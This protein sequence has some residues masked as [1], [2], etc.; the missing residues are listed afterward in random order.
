[1]VNNRLPATGVFDE[2]TADLLLKLQIDDGYKDNGTIPEGFLYKVHVDFRL[3]LILAR[4][5]YQCIAIELFK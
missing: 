3:Q 2:A 1:M 5:M 4:F